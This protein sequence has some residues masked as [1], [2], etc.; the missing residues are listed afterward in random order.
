[1]SA[2]RMSG[3]VGHSRPNDVI[4]DSATSC[5]C[6]CPTR[7][8]LLT[9]LYPHQT[10]IGYMEP[11]NKYNRTI[12]HL[13]GYQGFLNDRCRTIAEVLLRMAV[14]AAM[15]DRMDHGVGAVLRAL[16][17]SRCLG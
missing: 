14:Y 15:N 7:D 1:M 2:R 6:C 9:G 3:A 10:G 13:P 16:R 17:E 12:R 11:M 5:G 4:L 8:A